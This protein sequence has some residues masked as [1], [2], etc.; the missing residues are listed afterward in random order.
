[1]YGLI[2]KRVTLTVESTIWM[3][4]ATALGLWILVNPGNVLSLASGLVNSG[5]NL[6]NSAVA[7]VSYSGGTVACPAGAEEVTQADWE[8]DS[9]FAVRKNS[10]MLWSSLVCQPWVAGVFGSGDLGESAAE[11]Y[12]VDLL[13]AQG[14]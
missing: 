13:A 6:V 7:K 5:S 11:Y 2:R 8:S 1:W 3:V 12:A 10:D 4:M 9:D 14:I